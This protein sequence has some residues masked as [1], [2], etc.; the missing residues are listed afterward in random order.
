ML[1]M[2]SE[3]KTKKHTDIRTDIFKTN[4]NVHPVLYRLNIC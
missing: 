1:K 2:N 4:D 3:K